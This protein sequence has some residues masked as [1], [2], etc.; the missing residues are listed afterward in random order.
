LIEKPLFCCMMKAK[1][2]E[3]SKIQLSEPLC[4]TLWRDFNSKS[5]RIHQH[6]KT[7]N[8]PVTIAKQATAGGCAW[9]RFATLPLFTALIFFIIAYA[10]DAIM[11]AFQ[12][13]CVFSPTKRINNSK[14]SCVA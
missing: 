2:S 6:E 11:S 7:T 12:L 9:A 10:F 5:T 4:A 14:V 13:T 1:I 8:T 3:R